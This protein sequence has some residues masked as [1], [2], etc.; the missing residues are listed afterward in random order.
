MPIVRV[1]GVANPM[2][3]P[4]DMDIDDI[5]AFLQ[6]RFTKRAISGES[7]ALSKV[8]DTASPYNPSLVD[9][10]GSG[11]AG[12]LKDAGLISDNYR[13]Q[14]IGKNLSAIGEFLPGVGDATAGDEFGRAVAQG[15]KFGMAMAG[16]G[17]IP[18][19]GDAAKKGGKAV[20]R[21]YHGSRV[22]FDAFDPARVGDR[23]TSL[24]IGH[25][26]TP[27]KSTAEQYGDKLMEFDVDVTNILDWDN[28]KPEQRKLVESELI[29][30]VPPSRIAGFGQKKFEVLPANKDGAKRF[31]ELKEQTKD[32]Y[33]HAARAKTLTDDEI[34]KNYPGL[35]DNIGDNDNVVEWRE[36][37]NLKGANSQQLMTLMN[38]YAP[39][40]ARYLG[41]KGSRFA[42]QIAIYDP[43][44]ATKVKPP[45]PL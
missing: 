9:K 38:E 37:G 34:M 41:F 26:L 43:K 3:F 27:N 10:I 2:Q 7:D 16:L 23:L 19:A 20:E 30:I 32:A 45:A 40:L 17:V 28:L 33:H 4:D 18:V 25:Y 13:A 42:D 29:G 12:G 24:G 6:K 5:K 39:E 44:L 1:K 8:D 14:Q 36:G 11:I 15:D 31:K 21:L 22:E 35:I